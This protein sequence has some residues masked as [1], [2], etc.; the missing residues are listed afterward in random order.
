MAPSAAKDSDAR[1]GLTQY[2]TGW[3]KSLTSASLL[4]A[5]DGRIFGAC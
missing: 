2:V 4:V 5:M 1:K 3:R